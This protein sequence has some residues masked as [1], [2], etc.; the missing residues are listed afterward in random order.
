MRLGTVMA[1]P[2][3]MK[4]RGTISASLVSDGRRPVGTIDLDPASG[5]WRARCMCP[6]AGVL[7]PL[8]NVEPDCG[9]HKSKVGAVEAILCATGVHSVWDM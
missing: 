5:L 6:R 8:L 2:T 3:S 9:Q 4:G 7:G 1:G